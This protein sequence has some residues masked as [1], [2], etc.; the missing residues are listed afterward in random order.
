MPSSTALTVISI[1][2]EAKYGSGLHATAVL[3]TLKKHVFSTWKPSDLSRKY[4]HS[5]HRII[6]VDSMDLV[7]LP[8]HKFECLKR[9]YYQ[10]QEITMYD[11][12]VAAKGMNFV[13]DFAKNLPNLSKLDVGGRTL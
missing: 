6:I 13:T 8:I 2:P 4:Y 12:L 3:F 11:I 1:K 5:L 7:L 10:L 9:Y